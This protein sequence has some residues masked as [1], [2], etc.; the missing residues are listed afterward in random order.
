MLPY[1]L[2]LMVSA[3]GI[4]YGWEPISDGGMRYIV[5]FTPEMLAESQKS[6][7]SLESN[8]PSHIRDV[9]A[10]S[11]RVGTGEV[12]QKNPPLN[13]ELQ[14]PDANQQKDT[15]KTIETPTQ[16]ASD[17]KEKTPSETEGTSDQKSTSKPWTLLG[18]LILVSSCSIGGNL[19]LLWIYAELRKRF[20]TM[21]A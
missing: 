20:R 10:I 8:I 17:S 3:T 12:P 19:Y 11:I 15:Q 14:L 9:R 16:P 21:L 6:G 13:P 1:I 5:Q 4:N 2:L 7:Y 18:I